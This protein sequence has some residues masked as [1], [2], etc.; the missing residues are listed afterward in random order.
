MANTVS[1]FCVVSLALSTNTMQSSWARGGCLLVIFP[2]FLFQ[3]PIISSR[4]LKNHF[5]LS[6][7]N[8]GKTIY[9]DF[10]E[11]EEGSELTLGGF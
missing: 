11:G 8:A 6:H 3:V 9:D 5:V 2:Q 4:F 7:G 1:D 10:A